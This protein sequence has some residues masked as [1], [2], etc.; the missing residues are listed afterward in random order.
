MPPCSDLSNSFDVIR[1]PAKALAVAGPPHHAAHVELH[2][3]DAVERHLA[4]ASRVIVQPQ[5]DAQLVLRGSAA[6]VDL[7]AKD[8]EGHLREVLRREQAVQL[9][10]RLD[11]TLAVVRVHQENNRVNLRKI[12]L[13]DLACNLVAAQIKSAELDLCNG[14]LFR[15]GMLRW[16]VLRQLLVLQHVQQRGLSSVVEAK[17]KNLRILV[18]QAERV[19]HGPEVVEEPHGESGSSRDALRNIIL[20]YIPWK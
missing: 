2:R 16:V 20:L 19:E 5:L 1:Q 3:A 10:L 18:R 6:H 11:E 7:V 9:L 12:V 8:E 14:E 13:P 15:G 17:E 4:L